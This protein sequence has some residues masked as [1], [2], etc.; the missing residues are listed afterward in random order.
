M[1]GTTRSGSPGWLKATGNTG[2]RFDVEAALLDEEQVFL[3]CDGL[4]TLATVVLNGQRL[5]S[6]DN[7]FR[8]YRWEVKSLLRSAGNELLIAFAS[9]VRF[10]R[11]QEAIRPLI[12]VVA[13]IPGSPHLRKAPC[14]FGWDW[15]PM[16]PPI[17]IWKDIRLEGRSTARL[18][19]V[20]LRQSH[21]AGKVTISATV[22]AA[23][24]VR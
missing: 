5:A 2:A 16:L 9:P 10:C 13:A 4:D 3:V 14:Q 23:T 20:H 11:E 7:M 17:G 22:T 18:D 24:L 12:G 1:S 8:Q 19:D 6:T 15:G 21:A